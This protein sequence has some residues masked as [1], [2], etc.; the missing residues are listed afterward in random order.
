MARRDDYLDSRDLSSNNPN[1]SHPAH[2]LLSLSFSHPFH[3]PPL[4][5][6]FPLFILLNFFPLS[7]LAPSPTLRVE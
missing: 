5:T 1:D 4:I 2:L 3:Y 7:M 6:A